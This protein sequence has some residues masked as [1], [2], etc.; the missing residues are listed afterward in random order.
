VTPLGHLAWA[1][2][3]HREFLRRREVPEPAEF[4]AIADM[5]LRLWK[6]QDGSMPDVAPLMA[7]GGAMTSLL[8]DLPAAAELIGVSLSTVKRL[9]AA[10]DLTAVKVGRLTRI[11]R[12]DAEAYVATLGPGSFRD[13]VT[14]KSAAASSRRRPLSRPRDAG[15]QEAA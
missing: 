5:L 2:Q 14:A 7:D 11:R 8:L 9:V 1:V 15:P 13:H 4:T 12:E 10:G 6:G 3:S